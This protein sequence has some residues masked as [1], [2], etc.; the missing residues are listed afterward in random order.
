MLATRRQ[1]SDM[2]QMDEATERSNEK[3]KAL[4]D[5]IYKDKIAR[6]RAKDPVEKL[7]D[8]FRL[9]EYACGITLA[10]IRNQNP[11]ISDADALRILKERVALQ[12]RMDEIR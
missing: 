1:H 6:A 12:R 10:G 8:G 3:I 11:G 2:R 9:H 7:L 5:A 4:A